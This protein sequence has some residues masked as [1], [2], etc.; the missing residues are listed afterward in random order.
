MM[1]MPPTTPTDL[2]AAVDRLPVAILLLAALPSSLTGSEAVKAMVGKEFNVESS[3]GSD[4]GNRGR[5][6][7]RTERCQGAGPR[8][9][10]EG[11]ICVVS[12]RTCS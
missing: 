10:R 5:G 12:L 4:N 9:S 3:C 8:R 2:G 7:G 6:C 11:S 1:T